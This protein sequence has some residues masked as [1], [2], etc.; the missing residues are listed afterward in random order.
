[1]T[2]LAGSILLFHIF[3]GMLALF[4]APAAMI[5]RKGGIW[6]R[7]WGKV[8]FWAMAAVA[9]TAVLL[10]VLRPQLF[11]PLV[12]VFSFY[13]AFTGYRVLYRKSP[14][15]TAGT[16]DWAGAVLMLLGGAGLICYGAFLVRTSSFGTVSIAFGSIGLLLA[17]LDV[18]A[19]RHAPSDKRA[20][21]FTHMRRMMAAY[22]ATVTAFSAVNFHFLPP[23][24]R[25]LWPSVVGTLGIF[26]WV[27][28]YRKKFYGT[29]T[30][31]KAVT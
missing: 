23:V 11:L 2:E 15:H 6:H 1:M 30:R 20:W 22:I 7:R 5:T 28:H 26:A 31:S 12:A 19:F 16:L 17:I 8:Y 25:W 14:Q 21:W 9:V 3:F 10:S 18:R 13:L 29:K 24:V 4:V 27:S